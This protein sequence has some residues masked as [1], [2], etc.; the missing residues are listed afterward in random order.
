[1]FAR[2]SLALVVSVAALLAGGHALL[3][4]TA[5]RASGPPC[6]QT[7]ATSAP[8]AASPGS[9]CWTDVTPYPFGADGNPVDPNSAACG[10]SPP[11]PNWQGDFLPSGGNVPGNPPCYLRATSLAFRAWNR[12]LAATTVPITSDTQSVAYGVWLFNGAVWFPDPTFPGNSACPGTTILWAG[13]LDYWLI[14]SGTAAQRTLC[15]FDGVNLS[16]EPLTL[17][18]ATVARLPV[19][20]TYGTPVGG[21]TSGACFAWDNCW[22]FGSDGIRVHWDGQQ[23]S[24]A[25]VGPGDGPWLRGDFTAAASAASASGA[26]FGLAVSRSSSSAPNASNPLPSQPDG[27]PPPQLFASQGGPFAPVPYSP[28][29]TPQPNDPYT[30]DLT[31]IST[32]ATADV[33][34]AADPAVR[35]AGS[36]YRDPNAEPAPLLRLGGDGGP[37]SCPGYG[38][39]TFTYVPS[40]QAGYRWGAL[41]T[42]PNDGS[43]AAGAQF[44]DYNVTFSPGPG[45]QQPDIEPEIVRAGCGQA[46]TLSRFRTPDPLAA[47]PASAQPVPADYGGRIEALAANAANDAWAA[48]SDG[49]WGYTDNNNQPHGGPQAPHLYRFTDGQAPQ[50]PAGDDNESRPSLFTLDPPIYQPAPQSIVITPAPVTV[51]RHRRTKARKLKP[52]IYGLHSRLLHG[53]SGA[54]ALRISFSVRRPVTLGLEALRGQRVVATTGLHRFS[55]QHGELTLALTRRSWPTK[56]RLIVP[57]TKPGRGSS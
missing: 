32:D 9:P 50:A 30:T 2:R 19:D 13:K 10:A 44:R 8:R 24:D 53:R 15:R 42:F 55:G 26:Q 7:D 5:A 37:V 11:G 23:L 18:S 39:S 20:P 56:L 52:A 41:A 54:V 31:Q 12:G 49:T 47:N 48:S 45:A 22:F 17:P 4:P 36:P 46:P 33:W 25:S 43:A 29:A 1:M 3:A 21:V 57:R 40:T 34:V 38:P 28:P 27:S 51:T 16:W 35:L 14:G 6:A